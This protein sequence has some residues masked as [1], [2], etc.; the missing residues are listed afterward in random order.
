MMRALCLCL[1]AACGG[2]NADSTDTA[3]GDP[4]ARAI[5]GAPGTRD[6]ATVDA[7]IDG[8][9]PAH[10]TV[11]VVPFEN[12]GAGQVYGNTASAPYLNG[13]LA[14][15]AYATKFQDELTSL[16]SE[17]HYVWMEAGTNAFT[18]HTFIGD[19]D[20]TAANSAGSTA[21]LSTQLVA[22]GRTWTA[23]QEGITTGACPIASSGNYAAKH[24]PFVFFRDVVGSPPSATTATCGTHHKALADLAGDLAA[25]T[26]ANYAF[27]TPDLCHD[28]HGS[29]SCPSGLG[30]QTNVKAGDDWAAANLP[31]MI[32]YTHS[33]DAVLML[34]WDEGD[35]SNLMPFL[36]IGDHVVPGANTTA[37]SHSSQLKTIE[38]L[39]GVPTLPSVASAA[40]FA[41]M[42]Q[43]GYLVP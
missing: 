26:V 11:I 12:K 43:P 35:S 20:A 5:D 6:G 2:G 18:D 19:G 34:V 40:D 41:A 4:D 10:R 25:G 23:Y 27:V 15:A 22:A 13:L 36:M 31:A 37:Y 30:T 39:L 24:D 7:P 1:V 33:H 14:T 38:E 16:P 28:M 42:F 8:S 3:A 17:P 9:S 32:A 21:H 29:F